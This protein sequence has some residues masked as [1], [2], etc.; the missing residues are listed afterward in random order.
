MRCPT[1]VAEVRRSL[2]AYEKGKPFK[3]LAQRMTYYSSTLPKETV[4]RVL[5]PLDH[6]RIKDLKVELGKKV[7]IDDAV[8]PVLRASGAKL[9]PYCGNA[10]QH[11]GGC[12][13]IV[14]DNC[15][16]VFDWQIAVQP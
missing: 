9:C 13:A 7:A 15:T 12:N 11:G 16:R 5:G 2:T 6:L 8:R 3:L 10:V 4:S 1:C 14:C